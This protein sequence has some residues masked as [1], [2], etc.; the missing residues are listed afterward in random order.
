MSTT[1]I[2]SYR[3]GVL[4]LNE[5]RQ[6]MTLLGVPYG[7]VV[8]LRCYV[9]G[10]VYKVEGINEVWWS[11]DEQ[12]IYWTTRTWNELWAWE[13]KNFGKVDEVEAE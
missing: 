12:L 1:E 2:R 9:T 5:V 8:G 10:K 4:S 6:E 7:N 11:G 3:G 13:Y